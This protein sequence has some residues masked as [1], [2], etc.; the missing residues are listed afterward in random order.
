[1]VSLIRSR[2]PTRCGVVGAAGPWL[3]GG[4]ERD[5]P[6]DGARGGNKRNKVLSSR[7]QVLCQDA[8]EMRMSMVDVG[9]K[10]G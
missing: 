10:A 9:G 2:V 7:V 8:E 6:A 3:P 1:M 5:I 4:V